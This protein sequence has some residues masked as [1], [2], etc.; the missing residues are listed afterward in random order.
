MRSSTLRPPMILAISLFWRSC[1][2]SARLSTPSCVASSALKWVHTADWS[3]FLFSIKSSS[4]KARYCSLSPSCLII[5]SI[6]STCSLASFPWS[7][8]R[9][10]SAERAPEPDGSSSARSLPSAF[11]SARLCAS[12]M[13][14]RTSLRRS[15]WCPRSSNAVTASSDSGSGARPSTWAKK[16]WRRQSAAVKRSRKSLCSMPTSSGGSLST[17]PTGARSGCR[18]KVATMTSCMLLPG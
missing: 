8:A 15:C 12:A 1:A 14:A 11:S 7:P 16:E 17:C 2:S 13:R 10:C 6:P 3:S 4:M 5:W 18:D 9:T